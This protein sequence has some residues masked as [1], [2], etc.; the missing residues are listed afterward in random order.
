MRAPENRVKYGVRCEG[1]MS[2]SRG[3]LCFT[4]FAALYVKPCSENRVKYGARGAGAVSMLAFACF[5]RCFAAVYLKSKPINQPPYQ[6]AQ[7]IQPPAT[8]HQPAQPNQPP[9][10][11]PPATSHPPPA[12][13]HQPRGGSVSGVSFCR[14][15][16][17]EKRGVSA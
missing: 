13:S 8:C 10:S 11:Q 2:R 12:T 14:K 9:A 16:M 1:A 6:P 15:E 4:V 7:P 5:L 3:T 17:A